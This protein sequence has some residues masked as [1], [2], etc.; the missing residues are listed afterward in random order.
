M[1]MSKNREILDTW[2]RR[3]WTER[4]EGAIHE[5]FS[6]AGSAG[7]MGREKLAGPADFVPFHQAI[8]AMV[9][10][11]Q[12]RIDHVIE[13]G[14]EMFTLATF[15]GKCAE[16]G[17]PVEIEGSMSFE[18]ADGQI[19]HCANHFEFMTMFEQ[20]GL[21]PQDSFGILMSKQKLAAVAVA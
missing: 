7:G 21:L 3:V 18:F 5:L 15:S 1:T 8:C 6:T 11:T 13:Q 19:L 17:T 2:C 4:D 10:D 12:L 20:L 9:T 16:T 14:D